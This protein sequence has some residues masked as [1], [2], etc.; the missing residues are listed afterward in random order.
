MIVVALA[1]TVFAVLFAID[2][3]GKDSLEGLVHPGTFDIA[4]LIL[5]C[6]VGL[7]LLGIVI[8]LIIKLI[9]R[10]MSDGKYWIK[11]LIVTILCAAVVGVAFMLSNGSDVPTEFLDK[12]ET[13]EQTSKLIGTACIMVYIL[14]AGSIV[15]I[16][17]T[18]VIKTFK[19]R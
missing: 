19:K 3:G 11:F 10:F 5:M 1:A 12:N 4:Y 17:V 8:F 18:E 16:L 13:S 15:S 2:N 6:L 7:A 14:A 9:N